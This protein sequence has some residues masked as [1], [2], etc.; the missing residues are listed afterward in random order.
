MRM[1]PS[2]IESTAEQPRNYIYRICRGVET[3][4][5]VMQNRELLTAPYPALG[6]NAFVVLN[7]LAQVRVQ[8]LD[9]HPNPKQPQGELVAKRLDALKTTFDEA[10]SR[11]DPAQ[12]PDLADARGRI[13]SPEPFQSLPNNH[14]DPAFREA[15][16]ARLIDITM[17]E[18]AVMKYVTEAPG[19]TEANG[20]QR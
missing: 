11:I 8:L 18:L 14:K 12:V 9:K 15:V 17:L 5:A 10:C 3:I 16:K 1:I 6:V 13:F 7:S 19:T 20:E 2:D 4:A